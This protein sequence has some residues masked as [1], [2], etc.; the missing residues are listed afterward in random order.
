MGTET[1]TYV[2]LMGDLVESEGSGDVAALHA[3]FNQVIE[4]Q[5]R[6]AGTG[7][8]SPLTIT[9]GDEFQGLTRSLAAAFKIA[10]HIR[11][12]LMEASVECRFAMGVVTL[13]TPLNPDRAWNMM[14]PGLATTRERLN[15]KR[16][17]RLYRFILPDAPIIEN[18]LEASGASLTA[19]ERGW[20]ETQRRDIEA[21][22][23][24]QSTAEVARHRHV[25]PRSVYK[26]RSSGNFELYELH[27]HT[28]RTT[29]QALDRQ[30]GLEEAAA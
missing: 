7:I 25:S 4:Q 16:S 17:D 3:R 18:L 10:R 27:L 6:A 12:D 28:I 21:L 29:L 13:K 24:G 9:L 20:T 14:G 5:S 15:E 23:G 26:V 22:L 19:I 2:A 11:F 1:T 30:F 8:V